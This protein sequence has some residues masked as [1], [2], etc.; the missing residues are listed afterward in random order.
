MRPPREPFDQRSMIDGH[1]ASLAPDA[2]LRQVVAGLDDHLKV[3]EDANDDAV[4]SQARYKRWCRLA[5]LLMTGATLLSAPMLLPLDRL[6][7]PGEA[8]RGP[9][10]VLQA[11]ANAVA[12]CLVWWLHRSGAVLSWMTS[13]AEAERLRG[14]YF[15]ALL[16]GPV[17]PGADAALLL[18]ERLALFEAA[19]LD[20]Q[21]GYYRKAVDR[22]NRAASARAWPRF[23]AAMVTVIGI[24]IGA[25]AGLAALG[26]PVH[27][28]V[29]KAS[30]VLE[31]PVRWQ[32]CLN[33]MGSSLLAY[34]SA[35]AMITQDERNAA[36]YRTTL[37]RLDAVQSDARPK[38]VAEAAARGD[39]A[40]V[41][42]YAAETQAILEADHQV[43]MLNRPPANAGEAPPVR[44]KV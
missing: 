32:L 14:D 5:L 41:L 23:I 42:A 13:R 44:F 2:P 3:Y 27:E 12:L 17:P 1:L 11:F 10:S 26:M 40:A 25:A 19:H 22:H 15:R 38:R 4:K 39:A 30:L 21:R 34:A 29:R 36:L 35:R 43:W 9:I 28:V 6:W 7:P 8:W 37:A 20:Y 24:A 33:T 31:D 18:R 16:R